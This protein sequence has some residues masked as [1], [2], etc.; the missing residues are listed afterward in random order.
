MK[1]KKID[2]YNQQNSTIEKQNELIRIHLEDFFEFQGT[3][4]NFESFKNDYKYLKLLMNTVFS[5]EH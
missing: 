5:L 3:L 4:T 2:L 1:Q